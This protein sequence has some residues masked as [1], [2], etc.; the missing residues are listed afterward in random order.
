M[1]K[2]LALKS[3][4][5]QQLS[6]ILLSTLDE[7]VFFNELC[8]FMHSVKGCD[9]TIINLVKEDGSSRLIS[10]NG[11]IIEGGAILSKG[12]GPAGHVV[13]TRKP[14]FSNNVQRDPL[15]AEEAKAGVAAELC[16]PIAHE[17]IV[18]ATLHFQILEGEKEF[19]RED[20]TEVISILKEIQLP[21]AN[22]KMYLAAKF[23][24]ESL[25]K[26]IENK[27][28]ELKAKDSGHKVTSSYKIE[29]KSIIGKSDSM[30]SLLKLADKVAQSDVNVLI[31]GNRGTGREMIAKRIHCRSLRSERGFISVDCSSLSEDALERELFGEEAG[32][33]REMKVR[34]G[35]IEVA[36]GGSLILNNIHQ[37]SLKLQSKIHMFLNE[38]MA[39]R[40][41]GQMPFRSDVRI[42][43]ATTVD[44]LE[45]VKEGLFREEL[46]F[47]L[48]TLTLT[49][50]SLS[51]RRDD[52]AE[53]ATYF[54]NLNRTQEEQKALSPTAISTLEDYNWPGNVRELQ[55]VIER[56]Y[57]L[58][59]GMVVE[60]NHLAES[61][62]QVEIVEEIIDED[63]YKFSEMTLDELEKRH[64]CNTL[65]HL[66]GNKTKTARMLGI[67][68]K[69]L[70]NKL[71]SYDMIH[72]KEA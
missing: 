19:G 52:V 41:G 8:K 5:T 66:S 6:S 25:L 31:Q 37:L 9:R 4:E 71:H 12:Q 69:T 48:N 53:L 11:S 60:K 24:N 22:M 55:N 3:T 51:E 28:E 30:K 17:G 45:K 40:V 46:Y 27:E 1:S 38:K 42:F 2:N 67:T 44:L 32:D 33:F 20:M 36:N 65:D 29:E 63:S 57:I 64:I 18:I 26:Q 13:R 14:Y 43:A 35:M 59:D 34:Q 54:L 21:L 15:F 16:L 23:L 7:L 50:P 47:T 70:Y 56:A 68:V 10:E 61:V 58:S 62:T 72:A 49:V 39:F